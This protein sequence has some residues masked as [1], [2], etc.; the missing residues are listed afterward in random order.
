[1]RARASSP[2]EHDQVGSSQLAQPA[3][4]LCAYSARNDEQHVR[5]QPAV[6]IGHDARNKR[7]DGDHQVGVTNEAAF[8][9]PVAALRARR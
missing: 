4:S 5:P 6:V 2:I 3:G 8:S 7:I 1:M 9:F